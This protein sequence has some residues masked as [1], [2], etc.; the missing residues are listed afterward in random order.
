MD[1]LEALQSLEFC[2][3]W[4]CWSHCQAE[5]IHVMACDPAL[6]AIPRCCARDARTSDRKQRENGKEESNSRRLHKVA[7]LHANKV[8]SADRQLLP[9]WGF[10]LQALKGS[11]KFLP[12][13]SLALCDLVCKRLRSVGVSYLCSDVLCSVS[14]TISICFDLAHHHPQS[15]QEEVLVG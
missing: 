3:V 2:C 11:R 14:R 12:F 4:S 1:A 15:C 5:K 8:M 10:G 9:H 13:A 6:R 7:T